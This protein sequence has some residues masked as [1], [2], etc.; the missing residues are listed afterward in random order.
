MALALVAPL[1]L[2]DTWTKLLFTYGPFALLVFSAFVLEKKARNQMVSSP[3]ETIPVAIYVSTWILIFAM[4]ATITIVW[5]KLNVS[6]Q[7]F[8]IRGKLEGLQGDEQL[9]TRFKLMYARREYG[10]R[11]KFDYDWLILSSKKLDDGQDVLLLIDRSTSPEHEDIQTFRLPILSSFYDVDSEVDLFYDRAKRTISFEAGKATKILTPVEYE[12]EPSHSKFEGW[13]SR[14]S[15]VVYAQSQPSFKDLAKQLQSTDPI[16]RLDARTQ[17]AQLGQTAIP[18][19]QEVLVNSSSPYLLKLG[20]L[21]A[22]NNKMKSSPLSTLNPPS[23][24]AIVQASFDDDDTLRYEAQQLVQKN[25]QIETLEQCG[26]KS[27]PPL[28]CGGELRLDIRRPVKTGYGDVNMYLSGISG[29][30]VLDLYVFTTPRPNWIT[31]DH[32]SHDHFRAFLATLKPAQGEVL[33]DS[34]YLRVKL[35]RNETALLN[36]GSA[37]FRLRVTETHA[38]KHYAS[39]KMC[40]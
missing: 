23:R 1:D 21:S 30:D 22:L 18:F 12:P 19:I 6:V 10:E 24:C 5:I 37:P 35:K 16:I 4:A 26:F 17:L 38:F 32:V 3:G 29:S 36:L 39:L 8:R 31:G 28:R 34:S 20:S 25:P 2:A 7:E 13:M 9:R 14:F 33:T 15:G 40:R 27:T 11:S